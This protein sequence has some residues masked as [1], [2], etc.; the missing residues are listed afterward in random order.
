MEDW[1]EEKTRY[2][3]T[4]ESLFSDY[5]I[6]REKDYNTFF[7]IVSAMSRWY[8]NLPRYTKCLKTIYRGKNASNNTTLDKS[9]IQFINSLKQPDINAENISLMT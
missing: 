3:E 2:I 7:Y 8:M 1:N 5:I 6:E 9:L 4:L